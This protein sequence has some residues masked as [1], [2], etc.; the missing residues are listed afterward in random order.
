MIKVV[1]SQQL[2]NTKADIKLSRKNKTYTA[3]IPDGPLTLL[4]AVY[5]RD[6]KWDRET[7]TTEFVPRY[8]AQ[9]QTPEARDALNTLYHE[10]KNGKSLAIANSS[11]GRIYDWSTVILGLL[12]GA[13]LESESEYDLRVFFTVYKAKRDLYETELN[14]A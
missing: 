11:M 5:K 4:E 10:C 6:G 1:R 14:I 2:W 13:G 8:M 9:L 3:I 7:F 12:Q